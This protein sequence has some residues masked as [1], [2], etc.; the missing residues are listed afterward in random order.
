MATRMQQRRGTSA[1]WLSANPILADGE[2]GCEKDTGVVKVGNGSS[3]WSQLN[4]ILGSS[5]LPILGKAYDSERLDGLDSTAFVKTDDATLFTRNL[6]PVS[7]LPPISGSLRRGDVVG[8]TVATGLTANLW[9]YDGVAWRAE[10]HT[11]RVAS[12]GER[13]LY[14]SS[15]AYDG[16]RAIDLSTDAEWLWTGG[17]WQAS[18]IKGMTYVDGGT[19]LTGATAIAPK[20]W[21]AKLD[22][23]FTGVSYAIVNFSFPA[24]YFSEIPYVQVSYVWAN[25][26][27]MTIGADQLASTGG[28]VVLRSPINI[29]GTQT[30]CVH[31]L[32]LG[33]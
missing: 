28:I 14:T 15:V 4:P 25:G 33:R 23:V 21:V 17:I 13:N 5:Y 18:G 3:T 11:I 30:K 32:A 10:G 12:A 26:Y 9:R 29:N 1:Q 6:G 22:A 2:F 16:L 27:D 8:Y 7:T 31:L 24:G 20:I 19:V